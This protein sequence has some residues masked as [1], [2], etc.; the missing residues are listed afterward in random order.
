LAEYEAPPMDVATLDALNDYVAR[1][2]AGAAD[3]WY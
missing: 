1:K 2:K 3:A